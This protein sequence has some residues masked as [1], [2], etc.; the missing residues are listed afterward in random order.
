[1]ALALSSMNWPCFIRMPAFAARTMVATVAVVA[2]RTRA[3]G[4]PAI[5][6]WPGLHHPLA[7]RQSLHRISKR[8]FLETI[9]QSH[10]DHIVMAEPAQAGIFEAV[11]DHISWGNLPVIADLIFRED[12]KG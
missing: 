9:P 3:H 1:M 7:A 10:I 12:L 5:L 2:A 8:V 11:E 4:Q 6:L